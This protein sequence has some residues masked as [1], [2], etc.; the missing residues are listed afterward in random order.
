MD[1][2]LDDFFM[3]FF[4]KVICFAGFFGI[5]RFWTGVIQIIV[6]TIILFIPLV[7]GDFISN[8]SPLTGIGT[9]FV[10]T[11]FFLPYFLFNYTK[12]YR[13]NNIITYKLVYISYE[14]R[15]TQ[16]IFMVVNQI[17]LWSMVQLFLFH[18]I[19][20]VQ[21]ILLCC[22]RPEF[23]YYIILNQNV[24]SKH[25]LKGLV[26]FGLKKLKQDFTRPKTSSQL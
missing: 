22:V 10:C 18:N 12:D 24:K 25:T 11:I 6:F 17:I 9:V 16:L 26:R 1:K 13:D 5:N 8:R 15:I 19:Y 20:I 14:E 7:I 21:T 23:Y 2:K 4:K 3:M